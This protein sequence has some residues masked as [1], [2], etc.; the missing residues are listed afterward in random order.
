MMSFSLFINEFDN[1]MKEQSYFN[2]KM[3]SRVTSIRRIQKWYQFV[4]Q[5]MPFSLII[6]EFDNLMKEQSYFDKN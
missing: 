3:V 5:M 2:K 4:Q 6:D 1:L